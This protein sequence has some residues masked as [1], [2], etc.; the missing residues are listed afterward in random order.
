MRLGWSWHVLAKALGEVTSLEISWEISF[1]REQ[2]EVAEASME[3]TCK[4]DCHLLVDI[5]YGTN[6]LQIFKWN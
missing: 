2:P 5:L 4:K 3:L 1:L 6:I